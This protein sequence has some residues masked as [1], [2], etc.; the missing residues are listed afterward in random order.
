MNKY[1]TMFAGALLMAAC[2]SDR[3][4][5]EIQKGGSWDADGAVKFAVKTGARQSSTTRSIEKTTGAFLNTDAEMQAL[6]IGVFASYTD[7]MPYDQVTVTPDFMYN[8]EM[9]YR[10]V[11]ENWLGDV[12]CSD[13]VFMDYSPIKYWP[14][15]EDG[16]ISFF[17]YAPFVETPN[18]QHP[19][20]SKCIAG[21]S[22]PT[23]Q[24]DP[25]LVYC[26]SPDPFDEDVT[27]EEDGQVDLLFA[28]SYLDATK[29]DVLASNKT[30]D[31]PAGLVDLGF[32]HALACVGDSINLRMDSGIRD[33]IEEG[34]KLYIDS[35]VINYTNLTSKARLNLNSNYKANWKPII[36]GEFTTSR[37][38][39][40]NHEQ[41]LKANDVASNPDLNQILSAKNGL[42]NHYETVE[43][44]AEEVDYTLATDRG[45]F[46]IPLNVTQQ[47]QQAQ[48]TVYYQILS[49]LYEPYN[50]VATSSLNL[51][52]QAGSRQNFTITLTKN[53]QYSKVF[54]PQVGDFY[55][56][57]GTW[58]NN[59]HATDAQPVGTIA[60][61]GED[62][63]T[64]DSVNRVEGK[65]KH[66]LVIAWKN[67]AHTFT[68]YELSNDPTNLGATKFNE[69]GP[70]SEDTPLTNYSSYADAYD[71]DLNGELNTNILYQLWTAKSKSTDHQYW[72]TWECAEYCPD[73]VSLDDAIC[74]KG[75][76]HIGTFGE[77][78]RIFDSL[79]K[80]FNNEL[81]EKGYTPWI[82]DNI[83]NNV[84]SMTDGQQFYPAPSGTDTYTSLINLYDGHNYDQTL[85]YELKYFDKMYFER[86]KF[87]SGLRYWTSTEVDDMHTMSF[88]FYYQSS[89]NFNDAV[90][91]FTQGETALKEKRYLIRPLLTF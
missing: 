22:A 36:S 4:S 35:I 51:N 44:V 43:G 61:L 17:G 89:P 48:I 70:N 79:A 9:H 52:E 30:H 83:K 60:Y 37:K 21:F 74:G 20:R 76:W 45:L 39:I 53:L 12:D 15:N 2:S 91:F 7:Q 18:A 19:E 50:G 8:Q 47:P 68:S 63:G 33:L 66:G 87:Q 41:I 1:L 49:N 26:L 71:N 59:H 42:E 77:W 16:K 57:D 28:Y 80:F 31:V 56:S 84:G 75:K 58:G 29:A 14:N 65:A 25:S 46:Y 3:I 81:I 85:Y 88:E 13:Y 10:A 38:V 34:G 67:T 55:F 6:R 24:G 64:Y 90:F 54:K 23:D 72:A 78:A 82:E 32:D 5:D 40:L 69:W 27:Y 73:Y 11:N 62:I 86:N